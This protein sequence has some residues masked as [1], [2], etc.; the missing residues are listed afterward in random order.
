MMST[1]NYSEIFL[2]EA[3]KTKLIRYFESPT[4]MITYKFPQ[5]LKLKFC[6]LTKIL[7]LMRETLTEIAVILGMSILRRRT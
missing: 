1:I 5:M 6:I 4:P 3:Y 2:H 7:G